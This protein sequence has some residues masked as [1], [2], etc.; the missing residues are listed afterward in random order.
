LHILTEKLVVRVIIEHGRAVG[1]EYQDA[2]GTTSIARARR[3]VVLSAGSFGSPGILERSGIGSKDVLDENKVEQVVDLPR[4]G[5]NLQDHIVAFPVYYAADESETV[6]VLYKHGSKEAEELQIQ[7][8]KDGTGICAHNA[9]DVALKMQPNAYDL[10]DL[11]PKY[12]E[13]W[14]DDFYQRNPDKCLALLMPCSG[15]I[16]SHSDVPDR[17]YIGACYY[18]CYPLSIGSV[19]TTSG[20]DPRK[21]P[22]FIDNFLDNASDVAVMRLAY[23]RL[24][25]WIRRMPAYRGELQQRHPDFPVGS[26]AACR[27]T[28]GPIAIDAPDLVY[29]AEDDQAIEKF[30]REVVT[31]ARH[32]LGT[33]AMKPRDQ[34]GVV[35]ARLNV[36]G[37]KGLKVADLSI[38]PSNVAANTHSSALLIGEKAAALIAE[39]L[40]LVI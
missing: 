36:Y 8:R 27:E 39:D 21:P 25:E 9:Y 24:R 7:W 11:G 26:K 20:T 10:K 28:D 19:H 34:G 5:E 30:H 14:G 31:S 2:A 13:Q 15:I 37:V 40:G 33:C 4:V 16:G 35:D 22:K 32:A 23:K 3:N 17:K 6:D 38:A 29:S 12:L 1:V 18:M